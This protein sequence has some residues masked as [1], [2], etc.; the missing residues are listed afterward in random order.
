MFYLREIIRRTGCGTGAVQRE[1]KLLTESG[2]LRRDRHRFFQANSGS[3]IYGPLKQIVIRTVGLG[4]RLRSAL[5]DV[6]SQVAVAFIFGSF[7]RGEP[8]ERSD[9]D[10]LVISYD[11]RLTVEHVS[12]LFR[13]EQEQIGREISPFVLS[14]D[15]WKDKLKMGNAFIGRVMNSEKVFLIGGDDELKRLAEER[16]AQGSQ[17]HSSG[18][19]RSSHA[20]RSRSSKRKGK[21]SG[22]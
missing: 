20:G 15:E 13:K 12:A 4:D 10:V 8:D 5:S 6:V 1:L 19:H 2:I 17:S 22:R 16:M 14:V 11:N 21:G 18:S 3:P 7:A 9:V